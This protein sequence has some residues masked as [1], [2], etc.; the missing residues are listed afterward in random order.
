MTFEDLDKPAFLLPTT[1]GTQ[2]RDRNRDTVLNRS[3]R[4]GEMHARKRVRRQYL[5]TMA[6]F[7]RAHFTED[8]TTGSIVRQ[9]YNLVAR[10]AEAAA[11]AAELAEKHQNE[12]AKASVN[13]PVI[14][15]ASMA[16]ATD[17]DARQLMREMSTMDNSGEAGVDDNQQRHDSGTDSVAETGGGG[18]QVRARAGEDTQPWLLVCDDLDKLRKRVPAPESNPLW[19]TLGGESLGSW[20]GESSS[21]TPPPMDSVV[22]RIQNWVVRLACVLDR[23]SARRAVR[24]VRID[25]EERHRLRQW[26]TAAGRWV[27]SPTPPL[28]SRYD[29]W[30]TDRLAARTGGGASLVGWPPAGRGA[31]G[32]NRP[33]VPVWSRSVPRVC[34]LVRR[35]ESG[36][37][38][39]GEWCDGSDLVRRPALDLCSLVYSLLPRGGRYD[40]NNFA[41]LKRPTLNPPATCLVYASARAMGGSDASSRVVCT[42]AKTPEEVAWTLNKLDGAIWDAKSLPLRVSRDS[43]RVSNVVASALLPY[44]VD[45]AKLERQCGNHCT[46]TPESFPGAILRLPDLGNVAVLVYPA[47]LII[48]GSRTK[49][50]LARALDVAVRVSWRARFVRLDSDGA[51]AMLEGH[52]RVLTELLSDMTNAASGD[53]NASEAFS[54]WRAAMDSAS[55]SSGRQKRR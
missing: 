51:R 11:A 29:A 17:E 50:V 20:D 26:A 42:G 46:Y 38:V 44:W 8:P 10:A 35:I 21:S 33:R 12:R 30:Y 19:Y 55:T 41:A 13:H 22:C 1:R 18:G 34:D 36:P 47:K 5:K 53:G 31:G 14:P 6:D 15:A 54:P 24:Q 45:M 9:K 25:M 7:E 16:S 48:A 4:D 37:G 39:P 27:P 23:F 2:L 43:F 28:P 40:P 49:A 52:E 3:G 32:E